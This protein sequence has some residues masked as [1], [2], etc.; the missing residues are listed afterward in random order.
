[1]NSN[2]KGSVYVIVRPN[3]LDL[4]KRDKLKVVF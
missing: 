4:S 3:S 2:K 1:M